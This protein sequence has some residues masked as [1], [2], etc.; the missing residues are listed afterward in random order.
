[1][2]EE[3][4]KTALR[5]IPYGLYV[6]TAEGKDGSVAAATVNWLTQSSFS[7]PQ[8]VIGVKADSGAHSIIKESGTFAVNVLGKG[9]QG[10]AFNFFKSHER[11]GDTVGGETF[12]KGATGAPLLLNAPA[13]F[14][15]KLTDTI[16]KGDHSIFVGEVV[17]A[18]VRQDLSEGR[19]DEASA[20][21]EIAHEIT[22]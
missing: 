22:G 21:Y 2:D 3:A 11:E 8:V 15:C 7:P 13:W 17:D 10:L 16:E 6:L 5:M 20:L 1:M 12:E 18:G 9:Q 14:E 19:V 4:K